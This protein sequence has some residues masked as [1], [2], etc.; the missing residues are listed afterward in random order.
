MVL[1]W[2]K[3]EFKGIRPSQLIFNYRL[4]RAIQVIKVAFGILANRFRCLLNRIHCC[5]NKCK[6][7]RGS[8]RNSAK[9]SNLL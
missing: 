9:L 2:I 1:I 4:S 8:C 5:A 3:C 7:D 6:V